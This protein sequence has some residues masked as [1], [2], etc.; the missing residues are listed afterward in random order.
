[1]TARNK[2][3][4][5]IDIRDEEGTGG[6]PSPLVAT[7]DVLISDPDAGNARQKLGIGWDACRAVNDQLVYIEGATSL[8]VDRI[9]A[10]W[11]GYGTEMEAFAGHDLLRR[12]RGRDVGSNSW[13]VTAD[14]AGALAMAVL[15]D[16][17]AV[18]ATAD[19]TW[20]VR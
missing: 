13:S 14:A 8:R 10:S 6:V 16:G 2:L 4:A 20:P 5:T 11:R 19:W 3:V 9:L 18:R 17:R 12:Y 15:R 1:M 7:S